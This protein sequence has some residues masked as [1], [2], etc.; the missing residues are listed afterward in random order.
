MSRK[1]ALIGHPLGHSLSP[2]IHAAIMAAAG[3]DGT[4]ELLDIP[5]EAVPARMPSLLRD[6]DGFNATIPHKKAILPFLSGL[7]DAAHR[8]GAANTVCAGR[9]YTTDVAGF[10]A[11]GLPLG[12]RYLSGN[13][14]KA[15]HDVGQQF[16][17]EMTFDQ[18]SAFF[19]SPRTVSVG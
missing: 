12:N 1:F 11:A 8:C 2:E 7:S 5:P 9:G 4:Y 10:L 3:I 16:F 19:S 13:L 18:P 15:L 6:Y 14:H 17:H